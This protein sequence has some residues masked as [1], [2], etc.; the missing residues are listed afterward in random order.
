MHLTSGFKTFGPTPL[1]HVY[2]RH[3]SH[4]DSL[5]QCRVQ[6]GSALSTTNH[7]IRQKHCCCHSISHGMYQDFHMFF[8]QHFPMPSM[9]CYL[10]NYWK[11]W[12]KEDILCPKCGIDLRNMKQDLGLL[13]RTCA[14]HEQRNLATSRSCCTQRALR[15][16][17]G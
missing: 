3:V 14:A 12:K 7:L 17:C 15:C 2:T 1:S 13:W 5:S 8:L 10:S 11:R 6:L 16:E 9:L 4:M